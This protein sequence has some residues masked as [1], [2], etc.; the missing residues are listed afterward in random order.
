MHG[1]VDQPNSIIA[2]TIFRFQR[3]MA[4]ELQIQKNFPAHRR[5]PAIKPGE[6]DWQHKT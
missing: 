4:T 6:N 1:M 2:I 3:H 5:T